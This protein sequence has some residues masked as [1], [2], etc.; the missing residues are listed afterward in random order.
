MVRD[1]FESE[2]SPE[3]Q[4]V[5]DVLEDPACRQIVQRADTPMTADEVAE[6]ADIPL[7]TTY[8]K[9]DRLSETTLVATQTQV[10]QDGHHQTRYRANIEEV[11]IWLD[12]EREFDLSL[13]RPSETPD[14]VLT[15]IWGEIRRE[16]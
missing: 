2:P 6:R 16:T 11:S 8:R 7:S 3:L 4:E 15:D 1:P 5:L 14:E 13:R 12:D 9:L 10:R